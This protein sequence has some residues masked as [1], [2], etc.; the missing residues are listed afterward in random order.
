M[1]FFGHIL[2]VPFLSEHM[3]CFRTKLSKFGPS[4]QIKKKNFGWEFISKM[5]FNIETE[6]VRP[7]QKTPLCLFYEVWQRN[8]CVQDLMCVC[9]CL[10][11]WGGPWS[12]SRHSNYVGIPYGR[13]ERVVSRFAWRGG[14]SRLW[15]WISWLHP[16][17]QASANCIVW[18][19]CSI[20][21]D[22]KLSN[23]NLSTSVHG[24]NKRK[25]TWII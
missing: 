24:A 15:N 25:N 2:H 16:P 13:L 6:F 4:G 10:W 3:I 12:Y 23:P 21:Q 20:S 11:R 17:T 9:V 14:L 7:F 18:P 22:S 1:L 5:I 19:W 8:A